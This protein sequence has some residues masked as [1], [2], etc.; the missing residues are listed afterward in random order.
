MPRARQP[1]GIQPQA[2]RV[3]ALAEHHHVGDAGHPLE[4]VLHVH[5]DV[6]R[7]EQRVV[8][9][10]IRVH[11]GA[12]DE[13]VRL[14]LHGD[15]QLAH[16][17]GQAPKRLVDAVLDVDERHVAVAGDVEDDG[18]LAEPAVAARRRHVEHALDAVDRLFQRRGDGGF[19]RLRV[20]ARVGGDDGDLRRRN[21]RVLR[22]RHGRDRES[23]RQDDHE[24]ADS[25]EDG[26]ADEGVNEHGSTRCRCRRRLRRSGGRGTHRRDVADLL[27]VWT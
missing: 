15:A 1:H 4:R 3:L 13:V 14:L 16:F 5:V 25:R 22:H 26:A 19:D 27:Q 6:V 12:H 8:L 23:P 24:R 17:G 21:V 18:D 2:H 11:A 9:A 7:H 10:S 20:G